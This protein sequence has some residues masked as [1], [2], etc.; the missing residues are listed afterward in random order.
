MYKTCGDCGANLNPCEKCD[1]RAKKEIIQQAISAEREKIYQEEYIRVYAHLKF[2]K[3]IPSCIANDIAE[4][5]A[6]KK[7]AIVTQSA[8]KSYQGKIKRR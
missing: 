7:A 2:S 1:C 4:N 8:L 5:A 3:S 6:A